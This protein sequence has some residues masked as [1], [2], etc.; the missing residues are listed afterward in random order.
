MLTIFLSPKGGSGTTTVAACHALASAQTHGRA[1]LIDLCGDAPA[2]LGMAEPGAPGINDW[3][4]ESQAAGPD[5][6]VA[7]GSAQGALLVIHRGSRFVHGEPRWDALVAAA[8][9]W[10][11]PVVIDAGTH[12]IPDTLRS[13]ADRV[14]MVTRQ[15][16]L[17][18]RRATALPRP[19][20]I[21]L[22]KEEGRVLTVKDV[23]SVLGTAVVAT[24]PVDPSV[25][26]A[27]DAGVLPAR[28]ADLVSRRLDAVT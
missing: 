26:R 4:A 12:F 21:V 14:L 20:G 16:Y 17:A 15:C 27:V 7:L 10:D 13:A 19:S 9:A 18:L 22:V 28:H 1:V 24:V 25:A 5:E 6:L 8:A 11:C 23:E 2:V 3:L